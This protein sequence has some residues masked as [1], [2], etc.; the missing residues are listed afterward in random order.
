[1]PSARRAIGDVR[2]S[3]AHTHARARTHARTE[4]SITLTA[5]DFGVSQVRC[6]NA[7]CALCAR[8]ECTRVHNV[9]HTHIHT[10][11]H[12]AHANTALTL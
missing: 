9:Q 11:I 6:D 12:N 2:H 5:L 3:V 4:H 8:C 1:M 7:S 10:H